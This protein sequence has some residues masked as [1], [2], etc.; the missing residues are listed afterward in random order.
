V[1]ISSDRGGD[2][3]NVLR[4]AAAPPRIVAPQLLARRD[5]HSCQTVKRAGHGCLVRCVSRGL[6]RVAVSTRRLGVVVPH[7]G[8][9]A[10]TSSER[11]PGGPIDGAIGGERILEPGAALTLMTPDPPEPGEGSA[12]AERRFGVVPSDG[13]V[14]CC[15]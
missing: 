6:E 1:S 10:E 8:Q 12:E 7:L 13:P 2:K 5:R 3:P 15:S 9:E 4:R 14:K 11:W